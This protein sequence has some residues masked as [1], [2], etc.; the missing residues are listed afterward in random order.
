MRTVGKA[1]WARIRRG[2]LEL[3]TTVL[4]RRLV[5]SPRVSGR[6]DLFGG[7]GSPCHT[8]ATA[9][10]P[11]DLHRNRYGLNWTVGSMPHRANGASRVFGESSCTST[12]KESSNNSRRQYWEE[13]PDTSELWH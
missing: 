6:L 13:A 7:C 9:L 1:S 2:S 10:A 12:A 11:H 8:A 3:A 5:R 4:I